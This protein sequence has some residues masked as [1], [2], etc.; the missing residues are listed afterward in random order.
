MAIQ[1][2]AIMAGLIVVTIITDPIAA[3]MSYGLDLKG[4]ANILVLDLGSRTLDASVLSVDQGVFKVITTGGDAY[5]GGENFDQR[6]FDYFIN[7]IKKKYNKDISQDKSAVQKLKR[8][9]EK[10]KRALSNVRKV[11]IEVEDLIDDEEFSEIL[12]RDKFE[13]LNADL[14][15]RRSPF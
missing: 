11:K 8:E 3:A 6:A 10:G 15:S 1:D 5:L 13:E 14:S 9:V 7:L 12:T 4:E 2:A